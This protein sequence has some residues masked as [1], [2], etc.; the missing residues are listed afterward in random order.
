MVTAELRIFAGRLE[1]AADTVV[2]H[3]QQLTEA[4]GGLGPKMPAARRWT[5]R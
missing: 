1:L 3:L 2:A 5:G 4:A